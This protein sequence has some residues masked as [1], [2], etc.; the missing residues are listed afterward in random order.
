[1]IDE[2]IYEKMPS[3]VIGT[4]DK[5]AMIAWKPETKNLFAKNDSGYTPPELIIQDELHL[6]SGPLGSMVGHYETVIDEFCTNRANGGCVPAK[7][8]ASTATIRRASEQVAAL[9]DRPV[10]QFPPQAL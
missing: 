9:F 7:I 2:D 8:V 5:F 3:L 1:V 10:F 6:I 4:V